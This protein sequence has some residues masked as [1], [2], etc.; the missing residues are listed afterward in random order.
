MHPTRQEAPCFCANQ[1]QHHRLSSAAAR[2]H[3][4]CFPCAHR[5]SKTENRCPMCKARFITISRK[6]LADDEALG[7]EEPPAKKLK[8]DV[9][10]TVIVEDRK[11]VGACMLLHFSLLHAF[12]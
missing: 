3:R 5:W 12:Q 11:Q 1:L 10:E 6:R 8:G 4:F 9:L 7:E 2:L